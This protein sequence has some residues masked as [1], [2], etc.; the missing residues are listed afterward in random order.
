MQ[1]CFLIGFKI[2]LQQQK[3]QLTDC[4]YQWAELQEVFVGEESNLHDNRILLDEKNR[5]RD[6]RPVMFQLQNSF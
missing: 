6:R 1:N 4:H 5:K 3:Q 2:T